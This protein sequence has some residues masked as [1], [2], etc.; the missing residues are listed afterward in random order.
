M[1]NAASVLVLI[2]IF[3]IHIVSIKAYYSDWDCRHECHRT[4]SQFNLD[5]RR[6]CRT[7]IF[8]F[9][10]SCLLDCHRESSQQDLDCRRDC[11]S[12][13]SQY[14]SDCRRD[15]RSTSSQCWSVIPSG[16][17]EYRHRGDCLATRTDCYK[18]CLLT[19]RCQSECYRESHICNHNNTHE[20]CN[21]KKKECNYNCLQ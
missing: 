8:L 18:Q 16:I 15:C 13:G 2:V 3:N 5:C 1:M 17:D 14:N 12:T 20:D 10:W 9:D 4:S 7:I 11:S 19:D 6:D 21:E